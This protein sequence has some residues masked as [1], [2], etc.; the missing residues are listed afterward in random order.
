MERNLQPPTATGTPL[1][2]TGTEIKIPS[3][4]KPE[5]LYLGFLWFIV[6]ICCFACFTCCQERRG[7]N[8]CR[9][10]SWGGGEYFTITWFKIKMGMV[11]LCCYIFS[12]FISVSLTSI[13]CSAGA[14]LAEQYCYHARWH[15]GWW[16]SH[17]PSLHRSMKRMFHVSYAESSKAHQPEMLS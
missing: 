4:V 2:P 12:F 17:R 1:F 15:S 5:L 14:Q 7:Q 6:R 11:H 3:V 10:Q 9:Y 13:Y 16:E 8:F